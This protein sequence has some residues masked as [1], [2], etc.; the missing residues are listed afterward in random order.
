MD[1]ERL[2]QDMA[3]VRYLVGQAVQT[4]DNLVNQVYL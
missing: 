4:S 2:T 1:K 3:R